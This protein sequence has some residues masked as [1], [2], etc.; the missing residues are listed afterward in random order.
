D[1]PAGSPALYGFGW[2][3]DDYRGHQR[4]WHYGETMGFHSFIVRFPNG[5]LTIIVLCNRS[6]ITPEFLALQTSDL[7][8]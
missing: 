7:L 8:F 6:D 4:M 3:L 5:N 2:F 1:R